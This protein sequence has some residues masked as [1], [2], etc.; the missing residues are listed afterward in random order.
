MKERSDDMQEVLFK[1]VKTGLIFVTLFLL[2]AFNITYFISGP[3]ILD[4][5]RD[6]EIQDIMMSKNHISGCELRSR[7]SDDKVYYISECNN[8]LYFY[9]VDG[10]LLTKREYKEFDTDRV[11]FNTI[12]GSI[13]YGYYHQSPVY[14]YM[15]QDK[16]ILIHYD[17][18]LIL[19]N[20][21]KGNMNELVE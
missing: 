7:F 18:Y 17:S 10:T 2:I 6:L 15:D 8:Y 16:E 11:D 21:V 20:Y 1:V 5:K 19:R 14:V 13:S 12:R 4:K 3:A 9:D